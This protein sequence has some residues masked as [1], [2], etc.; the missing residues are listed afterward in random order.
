MPWAQT[1]VCRMP[2]SHFD[3]GQSVNAF[4]IIVD[5][6]LGVAACYFKGIPGI[7]TSWTFI[8]ENKYRQ[9]FWTLGF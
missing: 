9:F 6:L 3:T 5:L 8:A 1:W 4:I 7:K 2:S